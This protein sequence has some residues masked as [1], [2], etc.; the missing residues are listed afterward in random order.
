LPVDSDYNKIEIESD[1]TYNKHVN[2]KEIRTI[3]KH[4]ETIN[5]NPH[6]TLAN[7]ITINNAL[8]SNIDSTNVE[9]ALIEID[10]YRNNMYTGIAFNKHPIL[11]TATTTTCQAEQV[12]LY[13][14]ENFEGKISEYAVDEKIF[15]N[16]DFVLGQCVA[17][18]IEWSITLNKPVYIIRDNFSTVNNSNAFI[19]A[20]IFKDTQSNMYIQQLNCESN[21]LPMKMLSKDM[22][23]KPYERS[24]GLLLEDIPN[25]TL[26]GSTRDFRI[27]GGIVWHGV[28]RFELDELDT[29]EFINDVL[30][31]N[32]IKLYEFVHNATDLST[33]LNPRNWD[34]VRVATQRIDKINNLEYHDEKLVKTLDDNH[35][36][37]SWIYRDITTSNWYSVLGEGQYDYASINFKDNIDK[38]QPPTIL[39]DLVRP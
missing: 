14:N 3:K 39:P 25:A 31:P 26:D 13:T 15:Q 11:Q 2:N 38:C 9:E 8:F 12:L 23:T 16:S 4:I 22:E 37:V 20:I 36:N 32:Y 27:S 24:S 1:L 21:G 28:S 5:E 30:N 17:I 10:K 19:Y 18:V 35:C 29:R 33:E 7:Q 34:N 6:N